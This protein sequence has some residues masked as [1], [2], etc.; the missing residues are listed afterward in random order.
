[1]EHF[2]EINEDDYEEVVDKS[3]DDDGHISEAESTTEIFVK[4]KKE[5]KEK[6]VIEEKEEK[7]QEIPYQ[8]P[9]EDLVDLVPIKKKRVMSEKQLEALRKG[10]AK[11]AETRRKKAALKKKLVNQAKEDAEKIVKG[12][13]DV[14]DSTADPKEIVTK[15]KVRQALDEQQ[16]FNKFMGNMSK[17]KEMKHYHKQKQSK[18]ETPQV[19]KVESKP[20]SKEEK[21]KV[22][23]EPPRFVNPYDSWFN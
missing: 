9:D 5:K 4:E 16:S 1:M 11:S 2:P 23:E 21:P 17:Y 12:R 6:K 10:R 8:E 18:V 20:K 3:D 14:L 15:K 22:K 7:P 19:E 13:R